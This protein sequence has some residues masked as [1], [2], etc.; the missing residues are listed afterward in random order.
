MI[1]LRD[2]F[3]AMELSKTSGPCI[4]DEPALYARLAEHC[5]RMA[6]AMVS[7]SLVEPAE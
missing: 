1:S 5:Y 4:C 6:D 7:A 3:A 2:Y